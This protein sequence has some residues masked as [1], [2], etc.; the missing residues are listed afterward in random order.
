MYT[1]MISLFLVAFCPSYELTLKPLAKHEVFLTADYNGVEMPEMFFLLEPGNE[2]SFCTEPQAIES[3]YVGV[4]LSCGSNKL[5]LQFVVR[6][7][8]PPPLQERPVA[9]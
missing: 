5:K 3:G 7:W 8:V 6:R 1:I 4:K 2:F 9:P